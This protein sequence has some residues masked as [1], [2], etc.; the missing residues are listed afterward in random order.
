[1]V[2]ITVPKVRSDLVQRGQAIGLTAGDPR[3]R[4]EFIVDAGWIDH[5]YAGGDYQV[6]VVQPAAFSFRRTRLPA[7]STLFAR[8]ARR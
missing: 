2:M 3:V 5:I 1:M 8:C 4:R 6:I 7:P